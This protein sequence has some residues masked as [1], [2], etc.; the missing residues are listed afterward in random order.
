MNIIILENIRKI[1]SEKVLLND[2]LFGI[3][4]GDKIGL[5]GLN[6][7]GKF[8]FLKIVG[9]KEEFF[10]GVIIKGKNIRIEFLE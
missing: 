9:G 2:V 5:I 3:N 4:D 6:G 1:Y 7:V 10:E 8:I